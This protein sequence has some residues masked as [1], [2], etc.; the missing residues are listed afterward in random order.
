M[1][2]LHVLT[3]NS[4]VIIFIISCINDLFENG[5]KIYLYFSFN[6][7]VEIILGYSSFVMTIYG[8]VLL[9]FNKILYRG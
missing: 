6:I 2:Y 8:Y 5:P 3:L 7:S 4:F 9:S 1:L